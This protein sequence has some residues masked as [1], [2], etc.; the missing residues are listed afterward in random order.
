[1]E[2]ELH[3]Y[4]AESIFVDLH[5]FFYSFKA[6]NVILSLERRLT[7]SSL[8]VFLSFDILALISL[9]MWHDFLP[10]NSS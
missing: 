7:L 5:C 4:V 8:K 2:Q 6:G 1:M 10:L 9:Q 3:L